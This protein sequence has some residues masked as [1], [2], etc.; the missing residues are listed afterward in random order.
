MTHVSNDYVCTLRRYTNSYSATCF[1][2]RYHAKIKLDRTHPN[3]QNSYQISKWLSILPSQCHINNFPIDVFKVF[4]ER[5]KNEGKY[6]TGTDYW[7][8][9]LCM[10][11]FYSIHP[12]RIFD[13]LVTPNIF[14]LNF[15]HCEKSQY[16]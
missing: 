15:K 9:Y 14:M 1:L 4:E 16:Q 7:V 12:L 6:V 3:K 10:Y 5:K 11:D 2:I 13:L 8:R